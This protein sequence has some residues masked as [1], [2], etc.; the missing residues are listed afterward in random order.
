MADFNIDNI[1][2]RFTSGGVRNTYFSVFITPMPGGGDPENKLTFTCKAAQLPGTNI[3]TIEVPF[4]GRRIKFA[5]DRTYEPWNIMVHNDEDFAVRHAF[6]NWIQQMNKTIDNIS[7]LANV[8]DY[9]A[10]GYVEQY[11]R[12]GS[13]IRTYKFSGLFP[14]AVSP[15]EVDWG[16]FDQ[17]EEF[18]VSLQYDYFTIVDGPGEINE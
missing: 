9:K 14:V 12:T 18:Q 17:I 16:A 7:E 3:G 1:R 4:F 10:E 6:E 15:I 5:G 2:A 8:N 13:I 11:S